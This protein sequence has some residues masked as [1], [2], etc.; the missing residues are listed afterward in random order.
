MVAPCIS[1]VV[2]H[3]QKV[4]LVKGSA[5]AC[6]KINAMGLTLY[7]ED[8]LAQTGVGC[9]ANASDFTHLPSKLLPSPRCRDA[10]SCLTPQSQMPLRSRRTN[11]GGDLA[12]CACVDVGKVLCGLGAPSS[13]EKLNTTR[14]TFPLGLSV[15]LLYPSVV[16]KPVQFF[17]CMGW[18]DGWR[19]FCA[20][21]CAWLACFVVDCE[22]YEFWSS[23][24]LRWR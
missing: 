17:P 13:R 15:C 7:L 21:R 5:D 4:C 19:C 8:H 18:G 12:L 3:G 14:P 22:L 11:G 2:R 10:C 16:C 24:T 9:S 23:D 20:W 1:V 6:S